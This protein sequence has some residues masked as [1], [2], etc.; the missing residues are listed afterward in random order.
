MPDTLNPNVTSWLVY[1]SSKELPQ[2][3]ILDEFDPF[4]DFTLVPQDGLELFDQVD[5]SLQ[6]DFLMADLGDGSN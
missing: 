2:A 6:M 3:D 4:D 5:Q 1:D